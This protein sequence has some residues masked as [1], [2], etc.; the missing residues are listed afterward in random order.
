MAQNTS[1]TAQSIGNSDAP[2]SPI[3]KIKYG[4]DFLNMKPANSPFAFDDPS[5]SCS[6]GINNGYFSP[7][8]AITVANPSYKIS[9]S[10]VPVAGGYLLNN[11]VK[12]D[13]T[14]V[15]NC[16]RVQGFSGT[17]LMT[18]TMTGGSSNSSPPT[19]WNGTPTVCVYSI[20]TNKGHPI[21]AKLIQ[22]R[23]FSKGA[24]NYQ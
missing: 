14:T 2:L 5:V 15:V 12:Q 7:I 18:H 9:I 4:F 22:T 8:S 24:R 23:T 1:V 10:A 17:I 13:N 11:G 21:P 19:A 20:S 16:F 6:S 3:L